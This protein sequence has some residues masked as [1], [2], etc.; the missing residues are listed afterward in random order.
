MNIRS[1]PAAAVL[2][3]AA[4]LPPVP[5]TAQEKKSDPVQPKGIGEATLR[6]WSERGFDGGWMRARGG[7]TWLRSDY[8][9][10]YDDAMPALWPRGAGRNVTDE[11]LKDLPPVEVPFALLL[12]G[13]GAVTDAGVEHVAGLK[14][15]TLLNLGDARVTDEGLKHLARSGSLATLKLSA[16]DVTDA[17]LK[18]LA[19]LKSLTALHLGGAGVTDEGLKELGRLKDLTALGVSSARVT[20]AGVAHLAGLKNLTELYLGGTRVSD[21]GLKHLAGLAKLTT[22]GVGDTGVTGSGL[23]H[24]TGLK[25]LTHIDLFQDKVTDEALRTMQEA[26]LLHALHQAE[27]YGG[28]KGH[29][30]DGSRPTS[31]EEV[32][33]FNLNFTRVTGAGVK[34][35]ADLKNLT[36]LYL[37]SSQV[38]GEGLKHAAELKNLIV[39]KLGSAD[40][41]GESLKPLAGL[42]NLTHLELP[43][44]DGTLR[45]LHEA[46]LL[47]RLR[48]AAGAGGKR[49][50]RADEVVSLDLS[51][52][53]LKGEGLKYVARLKN[54][55]TLNLSDTDVTDDAIA[56]LRKAL[57][58]CKITK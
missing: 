51:G 31:Q 58:D 55:A 46:E 54:L 49:P 39:L 15:L 33:T 23:K 6:A 43:I 56:E 20:D 2:V 17:G 40:V 47:H 8:P 18:H 4:S 26:G 22:L 25:R 50:T 27:V 36:N 11:T 5:A 29:V 44:T 16:A 32:R 1:L 34:Y 13:R 38:T 28:T 12:H 19:G 10:G 7:T 48:Q 30:V 14:N 53:R 9:K 24:L 52:A 37:D 3:C 45:A 21:E 42:K 57:P 35:L 41:T